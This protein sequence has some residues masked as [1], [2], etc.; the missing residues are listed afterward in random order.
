MQNLI[1][2]IDDGSEAKFKANRNKIFNISVVTKSIEPNKRIRQ[3]SIDRISLR[4]I[5]FDKK[6]R[7]YICNRLQTYRERKIRFPNSITA[8]NSSSFDNKYNIS[9]GD[10]ESNS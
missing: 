7:D 3:F 9:N 5:N 6:N 10:I 1:N 4:P 2:D 8:L